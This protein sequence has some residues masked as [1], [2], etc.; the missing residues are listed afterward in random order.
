MRPSTKVCCPFAAPNLD[1]KDVVTDRLDEA[2][3]VTSL[4]DAAVLE[5]LA[6]GVEMVA[7][8]ERGPGALRV[9]PPPPPP[10]IATRTCAC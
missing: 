4:N 7:L 6:V 2:D 5:D 9:T 8:D 10:T 3:L 1:S